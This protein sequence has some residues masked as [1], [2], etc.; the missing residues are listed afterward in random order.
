MKLIR[1]HIHNFGKLSDCEFSF[2]NGL[3]VINH[4]NAWG[5]STLAAFLKAMFYGF[6]SKKEAKAVA[7]D[8]DL[9]RPWQ[10]GTFG[11]ELDFEVNGK[12]YRVSRTFG[13]TDKSDEFH[14]Y[15]LSTNLETRDY[16]ANLGGDLFDLD[17]ASFKRSI[18]IA[19]NDCVSESSD[20]INAK[21]GNL[22]ENTNDINNF[23]AAIKSLKDSMN[24]L[25]PDRVTGSIKRRKSI[26]TGLE[27]KIK[28]FD[29]AK[30]QLGALEEKLLAKQDQKKEM[31]AY[32]QQYAKALTVASEETKKKALL[33]RYHALLQEFQNAKEEV[34]EY[35]RVFPQGM[36][37][38]EDLLRAGELVR[39]IS[40]QKTTTE[41]F[42][43]TE[44]ELQQYQSLERMFDKKSLQPSELEQALNNLTK[45]GKAKKDILE[46]ESKISYVNA[47]IE[48]KEL[49]YRP[50]KTKKTGLVVTATVLEVLGALGAVVPFA[51]PKS[52]SLFPIAQIVGCIVIA[53]GLVILGISASLEKQA[54]AY[55]DAHEEERRKYQKP[56]EELESHMKELTELVQKQE[57]GVRS[58]LEGFHIF[59]APENYQA[60]LYELKASAAEYDRF[61]DRLLKL[62][63]SKD[64]QALMEK[65]LQQIFA[66]IGMEA[67]GEAGL[68]LGVLQEKT[69][70]YK[71][72]EKVLEE[73]TQKLRN[74]EAQYDIKELN[75]VSDCPYTL[76]ELNEY[77][78]KID[79]KVE[80]IRSVI[81]QLTHQKDMLQKQFEQK[82]DL[83]Q[84]LEV[85]RNLQTKQM[86]QYE[87]LK[88]TGEYLQSSK[89]QFT[90]RYMAPISNGFEKYYG[91]LAENAEKNWQIDANIEVKVKEC[92]Q[93]H[94]VKYLSAGYQDLIGVCMRLALVDAM[95]REE[96]PFLLLDDPFVNLDD[97]KIQ[98]GK[99]ML[100]EVAKEYQIIYFTC[101]ESRSME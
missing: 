16:S 42:N 9:Y 100:E 8:R 58:Y 36:P 43:L 44:D 94:E 47:S 59:C 68:S 6:D 88:L 11:G 26:I 66:G 80:E 51:L 55:N 35:R 69:A 34:E 18:F 93:L 54:K 53:I 25:S 82:E 101:H 17:G 75:Q 92:G 86:H 77:I 99:Q 40:Q 1:C 52:L 39:G 20:A 91:M 2:E 73:A 62:K 46:L 23:E 67:A 78:V 3:N 96:K 21:L 14:L 70:L 48:R 10:G 90:A 81:E 89:E 37:A 84:E 63:K 71:M 33:E 24:S 4:P 83:E 64:A 38:E 60:K 50:K 61:N 22:V 85:N 41:N 76:E 28:S 97:R 5:K 15:D 7:K 30:E 31:L 56:V 27:Q 19:Q 87:V 72:A 32:R 12:Q 13:K 57:D 45:I 65:E 79:A 98:Q 49:E 95:F 74:F 29:S